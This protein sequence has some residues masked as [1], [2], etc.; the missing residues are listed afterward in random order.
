VSSRAA[1]PSLQV[2]A[3]ALA[4]ALAAAP[5]AGLPAKLSPQ[6]ATLAVAPP[7]VGAWAY[8][9]KF[10]G[11]RILGRLDPGRVRLFTRNGHDWTA[12]MQSLAAEVEKLGI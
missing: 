4:Q 8:E 2:D 1:K 5:R 7:R 11:Y 3:C 6:L 10:D 9:I 12:K